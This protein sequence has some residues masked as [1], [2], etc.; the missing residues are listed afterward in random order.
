MFVHISDLHLVGEEIKSTYDGS[1][2]GNSYLPDML[3][4]I[5]QANPAYLLISGDI[6]DRGFVDQWSNAIR[7]LSPI[8]TGIPVILAPG[9]HDLS[10]A[11]EGDL[12]DVTPETRMQRFVRAQQRLFG[13]LLTATES[14]LEEVVKNA[15]TFE[16]PAYRDAEARL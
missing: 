7:Y 11:F 10:N 3:A 1:E 5:A 9:N 2:P 15:P 16:D 6:T 4:A 8:A 14:T 13:Q 12:A